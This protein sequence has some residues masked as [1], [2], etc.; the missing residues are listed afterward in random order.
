MSQHR[1]E[2]F[3]LCQPRWV[4]N[5]EGKKVIQYFI[6]DTPCPTVFFK[7][8]AA[9][10]AAGYRS[11]IK[12]LQYVKV[13]L[14]HGIKSFPSYDASYSVSETEDLASCT[15][16]DIETQ[17]IRSIYLSATVTYMKAFVSANGRKTKLDEKMVFKKTS[18]KKIHN[19]V[20]EDRNQFVA[21]AGE[22]SREISNTVLVLYPDG[23]GIIE[24]PFTHASYI[25]APPVE[26]LSN[27]LHI[28]NIALDHCSELE[29]RI[30]NKI[31]ESVR[32]QA[33]NDLYAHST[34]YGDATV[35]SVGEKAAPR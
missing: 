29:L 21:H 14:E 12:D 16:D 4:T 8:K 32:F 28:T 1:A 2:N 7:D 27:L 20:K 17:M 34:I 25:M 35:P 33:L 5:T 13:I 15:S 6:G 9:K 31:R 24:P 23:T 26:E 11:I 19:H 18:D 10:Q 22:N 30:V 3:T